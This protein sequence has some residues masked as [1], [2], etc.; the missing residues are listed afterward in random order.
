MFT[1]SFLFQWGIGAVHAE[2]PAS[3]TGDSR[4]K[5]MRSRLPS[6]PSRKLRS[7]VWLLPMR[8]PFRATP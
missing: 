8:E 4:R 5:G 2:F 1:I 6:L 3:S 7:C